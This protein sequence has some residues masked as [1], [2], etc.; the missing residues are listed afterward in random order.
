MGTPEF[1]VASL[2]RI[3][4]SNH[5]VV[6]VITA[7]DK[8]AGRGRRISQSAVKKYAMEKG[9][10]ILQ[11]TNLKSPEFLEELNSLNANLFVIVAFRML[12]RTVWEMPEYG[13]FNLHAS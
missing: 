10:R 6:G 13:T 11:P 12:P 9:L 1:A 7:P 8:P 3:V 4:Q 5:E 2:D